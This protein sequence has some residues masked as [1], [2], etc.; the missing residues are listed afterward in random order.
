LVF[1]ECSLSASEVIEASWATNGGV[2]LQNFRE[3]GPIRTVIRLPAQTTFPERSGSGMASWQL[4]G[5]TACQELQ[6]QHAPFPGSWSQAD[7]LTG[8]KGHRRRRSIPSQRSRSQEYF[9]PSR[10]GEYLVVFSNKSI[11]LNTNA[12]PHN[13]NGSNA[14]AVCFPATFAEPLL[15]VPKNSTHHSPYLGRP[16]PPPWRKQEPAGRTTTR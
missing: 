9:A 8:A 16:P 12:N 6:R 15:R 7:G 3:Q 5:M 10:A 14:I 11:L 2:A 13:H 4:A 1:L